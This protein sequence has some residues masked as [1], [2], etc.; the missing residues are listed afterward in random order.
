[1]THTNF[2]K[3]KKVLITGNT[4]FKGS[5]LSFV[6][7]DFGAKIYGFSDSNNDNDSLF[8]SLGLK[9]LYKT[10]YGNISNF[11]YFNKIYKSIKPDVLIHLAAQP[12]V[13]KS[14]VFP[15]KT[16]EDNV[17]G[18]LNVLDAIRLNKSPK[19]TL[20]ITSD[21]CYRNDENKIFFKENDPMGG[22][23]L[24][25]A[26]K[27]MAELVTKSF[28]KSFSPIGNVITLRAGNIFGGGD[29]GEN[30]L[31]PDY[32]RSLYKNKKII[33]RSP[34]SIR[35]WQYILRPVSDYINIIEKYYNKKNFFD[36]FN[37]GPNKKE[38]YRVIDIIK[39]LDSIN[40]IKKSYIIKKS[41]F[42]EA[43]ILRLNNKKF[44]KVF[45]YKELNIDEY[46]SYTNNWYLLYKKNNKKKIFEYSLKH[47]R[48]FFSTN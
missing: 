16:I 14:Y 33:I 29:F 4:G 20:I 39:K 8:N 23:D 35:P 10:Y 30:R 42:K 7:N 37:I 32:Y 34:D 36:N 3:N 41:N 13:R 6:L 5:W 44:R 1:M 40:N 26:S 46:L 2:W 19:I 43:N 47:I 11:K 48:E 38:H 27:G 17:L 45:K 22:N 15:R 25:S 12:Y 28:F 18:T 24:Y 9:K 21:K 31:L